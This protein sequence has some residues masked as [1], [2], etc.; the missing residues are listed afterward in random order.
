MIKLTIIFL[1]LLAGFISVLFLVELLKMLTAVVLIK[2]HVQL[3]F[4]GFKI[5]IILPAPT[6]NNFI[7][8]AIVFITPYIGSVFFIEISLIWFRKSLLDRVRGF[9]V[10]FQVINAGY[11]ILTLFI[12][13]YSIL[14][15]PSYTTELRLLLNS[16]NL[17]YIQQLIFILLISII[18]FYYINILGKRLKKSIP[19]KSGI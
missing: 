2:D 7:Y 15:R 9:I 4:N 8:N 19:V 12:S 17:T 13:I 16:A 3:L 10:V 18:L 14:L 5:N 6:K 1:G 11:L